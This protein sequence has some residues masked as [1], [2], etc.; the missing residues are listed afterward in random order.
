MINILSKRRNKCQLICFVGRSN[1]ILKVTMAQG[2]VDIFSSFDIQDYGMKPGL[3]YP[4]EEV[5]VNAILKWG[6]KVFCPLTKARRTKSLAESGGKTRGRRCLDCP[7]S[8]SRK[9]G[10]NHLRPK[11]SYKYTK[12]KLFIQ[13]GN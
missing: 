12:W 3:I 10:D 8:R 2:L 5:A 1:T 4:S 13:S 7:N 6:E 9:K 11:Q